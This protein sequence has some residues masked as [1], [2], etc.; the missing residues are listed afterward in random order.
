MITARKKTNI[1]FKIFSIWKKVGLISF[2]SDLVFGKF[3]TVK[4]YISESQ[5]SLIEIL[6]IPAEFSFQ[7]IILVIE[8]SSRSVIS[9]DQVTVINEIMIMKFSIGNLLIIQKMIDKFS[10]QIFSLSTYR[11]IVKAFVNYTAAEILIRDFQIKKLQKT[12][13]NKKKRSKK[14]I[15]LSVV[16]LETWEII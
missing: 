4:K 10:I 12:A 16:C 2:N 15:E 6:I 9:V 3:S 7:I 13:A 1:K 8:F 14:I 11:A 5:I